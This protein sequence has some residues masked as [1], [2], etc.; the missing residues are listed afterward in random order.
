MILGTITKNMRRRSLA[1]VVSITSKMGYGAIEISARPNEKHVDVDGILADGGK[2]VRSTVSEGNLIISALTCHLNLLDPERGP[3]F[4]EH[5]DKVLKAASALEV[6][7]VTAVTGAPHGKGDEEDF[8]AMGEVWSQRTDLAEKLDVRIAFETFPPNIA[9]NIPTIARTFEILDSRHVGLNFDPSHA[10]WQGIDN[11]LMIS[12]FSDRIFHAHAK[13]TEI[14]N[15]VLAE[16]GVKGEGWWR[17]RIP[18]WGS[19]DWRRLITSLRE[20]GYD[21]VLSFEHED[22]T[23]DDLNGTRKTYEFL[24]ELV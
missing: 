11:Y 13:D 17:F 15:E 6:P 1:E 12:R 3:R 8:A 4:A 18:G 20:A 5:F 7:V 14:R 19:V 2:D 16:K 23:F 22:K 9:Y 21:Y 10:V 24:K